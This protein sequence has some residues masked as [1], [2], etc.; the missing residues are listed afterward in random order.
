MNRRHKKRLS[1]L[2]TSCLTTRPW[3]RTNLI[4][5]YFM[6]Y[7]LGT[8]IAQVAP[9][10]GEKLRNWWATSTRAK[11]EVSKER[12]QH[13]FS[14]I[15]K[16]FLFHKSV[17]HNFQPFPSN[18]CLHCFQLAGQRPLCPWCR[19]YRTCAHAHFTRWSNNTFRFKSF[20]LRY[21]YLFWTGQVLVLCPFPWQR[22]Q[23]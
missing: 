11:T 12:N 16:A 18:N 2:N 17:L 22:R 7:H 4:Q 19:K 1:T 5:N 8:K 6:D 23:V 15:I 9:W 3:E 10:I 13:T 14:E 21:F 20:Q